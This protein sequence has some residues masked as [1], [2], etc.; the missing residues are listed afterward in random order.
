LHGPQQQG[1]LALD[2]PEIREIAMCAGIQSGKTTFGSLALMRKVSELRKIHGPCNFLVTADNYKTLQQ[3]T[4]PTALKI[5]RK[6]GKYNITKAEISLKGGGTVF[7]RTSTDPWS[8]EG[9]PDCAF[10]WMDEAG[11]CSRLFQINVLGRVARLRGQVLYTST[12]YAMNWFY[13]D[14]EK[15]C[16]SGD[17]TDI[18]F[19]RFS[20]MDNPSFP[21]EEFDRQRQLLDSRIFRMKYMGM[22]ERMQ[23]LVYELPQGSVT[24]E[25]KFT[26]RTKVYAGV[27]F[28]FAEGHEFALVIRAI[29]E[30]GHVCEIDE[31]KS[32]GLDP[33]EQV[34]ICMAKQKT[35]NILH[36]YCD[37]A[38]PDLISLMNKHG[39]KASG[40]HI[41]REAYK[42][43][44]P[45]IQAHGTLIRSGKY[46]IH[47]RCHNLI[48][49]YETYHWP[50]HEEDR[51][52]R[53]VPVAINDHCMDAARY[54]T[55]GTMHVE[56]KEIARYQPRPF[57]K[58]DFFD[59]RKK[60]KQ[61]KPWDAY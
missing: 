9:I 38:R 39:L 17:R 14:V 12:P 41:G 34:A 43:I 51:E 57:V 19:I 42:Q 47:R 18:R 53:E 5:F 25:F 56:I 31:Y 55:I 44:V 61:N 46:Q 7:F 50:E 35:Y 22:H 24:E 21:Q 10:A 13:H 3:A 26:A 33:T 27:D 58:R 8:V 45:G 4:I 29:S 54:L 60:V 37:P 52:A 15:P 1:W 59:P 6:L 30:D 28:G 20:S 16:L 32:A 49:E 2:D 36:F 23:G 11:K 40:F 48:D